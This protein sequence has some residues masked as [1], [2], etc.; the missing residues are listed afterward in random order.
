M[1]IELLRSF[2]QQA[3]ATGSKSTV[4]TDL[5]WFAAIFASALLVA[6]RYNA[7][8]WMLVFLS[9][10]LG[11]DSLLYLAAY[12]YFALRSPDALRSE[13]F[14]LSKLA[15]EKSIVGDSLTGLIDPSDNPRAL[16]PPASETKEK[17]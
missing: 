2:L 11:M 16:H 4:L 6:M 1:A 10:L 7:P 15:I 13:K 14:T 5:R 12:V 17:L 8:F 9:V 3:T